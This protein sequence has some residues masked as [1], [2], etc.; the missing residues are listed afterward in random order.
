MQ[1]RS[2]SF[3]V[4]A[5]AAAGGPAGDL[6]E[7]ALAGRSNVGK[8]S[9]INALVGRRQLARTGQTPGKTRLLN[10]YCVNEALMLVDLPGF[11][12]AK[13]SASERRSW[14]P[15]VERYLAGR[16]QLRGVL[17][18]LDLRRDPGDEERALLA[19]FAARGLAHRVLLTKSDKLSAN[20]QAS[21]RQAVARAL[22]LDPRRL[23]LFS[24]RT[25]QGVA[26]AWAA[27]EALLGPQASPEG[28]P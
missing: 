14:G 15:M 8:S 4:S 2:A 21:R 11:G 22:A 9:L 13:V 7:I 25:R 20:G 28:P 19:R 5:V 10:F 3:V 16:N 12:Y 26:E 18:V 17:L 6:P 23:I 24:A 27:I 1:I